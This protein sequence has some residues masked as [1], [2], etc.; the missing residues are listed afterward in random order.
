MNHKW[1]KFKGSEGSQVKLIHLKCF[2]LL[3]SSPSRHGHEEAPVNGFS[4]V[5][6]S[7]ST[8]WPD[9]VLGVFAPHDPRFILP[10]H[11]GLGEAG[12][13]ESPDQ[14][15]QVPD[16]LTR[17]TSRERQAQVLYTA[18][19]FIHYTQ[20][21]EDYVCAGILDEIPEMQGLKNFE[22]S[23]HEA[24][25]LL[26]REVQGLFPDRDLTSGALTVI[27]LSQKTKFDMS[28]WSEEVEIEREVL[29]EQFIS[30]AKEICGR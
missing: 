19:D 21:V 9:S 17:C 30:V 8:V 27:C 4:V 11:V 12:P 13:Q 15:Q 28:T 23:L 29:T 20:G 3:H 25:R 5:Y 22:V 6:P 2:I 16:I 1:P 7:S 24:P 14:P 18:S 10:G 26:K